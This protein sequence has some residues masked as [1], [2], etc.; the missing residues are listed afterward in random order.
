[1]ALINKAIYWI[2]TG[3]LSS[4]MLFSTIKYFVNTEQVSNIF[5]RLG[6]NER[7]VLPLATLKFLGILAIVSKKSELLKEWAYFG[8][9]ITFVL[10]FEG[11]WFKNDGGHTTVLVAL[12]SLIFS[13]VYDKKGFGN[14]K[15]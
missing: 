2:S 10:A 6:Y 14:F 15:V 1:M 13:Y 3:I 7:I 5:T 9:L 4:M 8:F 12:I 11:H